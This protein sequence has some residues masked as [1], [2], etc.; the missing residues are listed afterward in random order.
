[1]TDHAPNDAGSAP[2]RPSPALSGQGEASRRPSGAI[3]EP[4]AEMSPELSPDPLA[5]KDRALFEDIRFLGRLLG[6][7]VREQ[8]GEAVFG[9]VEAVRQT[10]VR[11]RRDG[12]AQAT[13][14]LEALLAGLSAEQT[15]SVVRAFSYFS[16]LANI[17]EDRH[18]NRR[19]RHYLLA[20]S[21]PR[22]GS[23][24][25][26]LARLAREGQDPDAVRHFLE[27]TLVVPVLTAHPTEVQRKSILDA[28]RAIAR[29][30][31]A[32]DAPA[33]SRE[34]ARNE[35]LLRA[36]VTTL[37]QTRM[38]R[39]ARLSVEDEIEN[40]L[41]YYRA[42]FLHEI[43]ALYAD[44][45]GDLAQAAA[46]ISDTPESPG[47]ESPG[48]ESPGQESPGQESPGQESPG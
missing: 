48:Q 14:E 17:A 31:A 19:R 9:V 43:P 12:E 13:R 10:A 24:A 1:M 45:Q 18:H 44:L 7:V 35:A 4:S 36:Q 46:G 34:H 22:T 32:R 8:E 27:R 16:H 33:S 41:S 28:Q 23:L 20:E 30:L 40:A 6:D 15:V 3:V 21:S 39:H 5:E 37:W 11:L 42:T 25:F 2:P 38:L 29:L 47:Q 26:A